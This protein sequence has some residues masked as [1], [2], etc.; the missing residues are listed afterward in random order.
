MC[1]CFFFVS[2]SP[3][4]LSER[5]RHITGSPLDYFLFVPLFSSFSCFSCFAT[6]APPANGYPLDQR[7]HSNTRNLR[8][9]ETSLLPAPAGLRCRIAVTQNNDD[10]LHMAVT[11]YVCSTR[12]E[13]GHYECCL[14]LA[15]SSRHRGSPL[16]LW[17]MITSLQTWGGGLDVSM[18]EPIMT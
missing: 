4:L 12:C 10:D 17:T 6:C 2:F 13:T 16:L 5:S 18:D 7:R 1:F 9:P 3:R 11:L 8:I 15:H 14:I